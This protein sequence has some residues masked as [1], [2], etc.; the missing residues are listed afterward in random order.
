[1]RKYFAAIAFAFALAV[2]FASSSFAQILTPQGRLTLQSQTPVM[3]TDVVGA[4]TVYYTPYVGNSLPISNGTSLSNGTFSELSLNV[5]NTS[6]AGELADVYAIYVSGAFQ[7]CLRTGWMGNARSSTNDITLWQGVWVNAN[8]LVNSC[9]TPTNN[10]NVPAKTGIYLGTIYTSVYA[11]YNTAGLTVHLKP[12]PVAGGS[13]NLIGIWNAYNRVPIESLCSDSA[14]SWT[15]SSTAWE[16]LDNSSTNGYGTYNSVTYVDGL[17]QSIVEGRVTTIAYNA[18]ATNGADIGVNEDSIT[19]T[20]NVR[21]GFQAATSGTTVGATSFAATESFEPQL[22]L[23][24]LQAMQWSP[25]GT[26]VTFAF[27]GGQTFLL[28]KGEY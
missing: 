2:L 7:L 20:P 12:S 16:P 21:A 22:G 13:R 15:D 19:N 14:T 11:G 1:M 4:S 26:A 27:N 10:Y 23:H 17:A 28:Y 8:T 3:T 5:A 9:G 24:Y 25:N 6:V 18:T